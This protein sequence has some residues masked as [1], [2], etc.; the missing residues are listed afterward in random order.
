MWLGGA[1]NAEIIISKTESVQ[2]DC[3]ANDGKFP[4]SKERESQVWVCIKMSWQFFIMEIMIRWFTVPCGTNAKA[5]A[6]NNIAFL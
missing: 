1:Y 2:A 6:N 5:N 4:A 3:N